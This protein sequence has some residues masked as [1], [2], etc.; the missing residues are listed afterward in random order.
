[1]S[2]RAPSYPDHPRPPMPPAPLSVDPLQGAADWLKTAIVD[3]TVADLQSRLLIGYNRASRLFGVA[4]IVKE[5]LVYAD[6]CIPG[7]PY[8]AAMSATKPTEGP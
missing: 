5:K 2:L 8:F 1:M 7:A 4:P 3:C 6:L